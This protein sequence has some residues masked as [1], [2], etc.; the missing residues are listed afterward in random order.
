MSKKTA[1][2]IWDYVNIATWENEL[3]CSDK[4]VTTG[5]VSGVHV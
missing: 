1:P 3:F 5:G 4:L 2:V